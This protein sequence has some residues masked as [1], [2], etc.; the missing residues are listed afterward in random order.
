[1]DD[2]NFDG[3]D[4]Y[5]RDEEEADNVRE[6]YRNISQEL[7]KNKNSGEDVNDEILLQDV[8]EDVVHASTSKKRRKK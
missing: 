1:M 5:N 3:N 7:I 6:G 8:A 2:F 4:N